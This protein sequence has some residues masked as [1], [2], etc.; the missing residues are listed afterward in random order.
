MQLEAGQFFG[1]LTPSESH[2]SGKSPYPSYATKGSCTLMRLTTFNYEKVLRVTNL[3]T[4]TNPQSNEFR[5]LDTQN[6]ES[7]SFNEKYKLIK[8]CPLLQSVSPSVL[9]KLADAI[10]WETIEAN[11]SK[12]TYH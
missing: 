10:T 1:E 8:A 11:Q 2:T 3:I 5:V 12:P 9:T 7:V 4:K 6:W